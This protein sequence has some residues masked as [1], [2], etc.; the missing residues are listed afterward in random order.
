MATA[1][2]SLAKKLGWHNGTSFADITGLTE[3]NVDYGTRALLDS[4]DLATA[5]SAAQPV[6]PGLRGPVTITATGKWDKDDVV[7]AAL[8]A[9]YKAGTKRQV[10]YT[11]SDATPSTAEWAEAYIESLTEPTGTKDSLAMFSLTIRAF[12]TETEA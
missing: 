1:V 3:I 12:G 5:L 7:H 10:K 2:A 11:R 9:D 8:L 4:S 6:V